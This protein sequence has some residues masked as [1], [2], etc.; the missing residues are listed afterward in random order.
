M[1]KWKN[2]EGCEGYQVSDDG[3][4]RSIDRYIEYEASNQYTQFISIKFQ[5]GKIL[6]KH[7]TKTGYLTVQINRKNKFIHRLVAKAFIPNPENLPQINH[8]NECKIDNRVENLEWCSSSYNINYGDRNNK[9]S[10]K[11]TGRKVTNVRIHTKE[12]IERTAEKLKKSIICIETNE[13]YKSATDAAKIIGGKKCGICD[14]LKGRRKTAYGYHW[15][16]ANN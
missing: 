2:I 13:I 6:K 8:K 16:Y 11:L 5:A 7:K 4:V 15:K 1:D 14:V 3:N 9:V 12:E 10:K